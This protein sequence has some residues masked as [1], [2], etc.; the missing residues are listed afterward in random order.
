MHSEKHPLGV[1][2]SGLGLLGRPLKKKRTFYTTS[3]VV[4]NS[5]N[6]FVFISFI[7]KKN[8]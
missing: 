3:K 8:L 4:W 2:S 6:Y 1:F 7:I 5:V